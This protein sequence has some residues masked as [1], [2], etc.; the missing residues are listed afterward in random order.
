[1]QNIAKKL[2]IYGHEPEIPFHNKTADYD[3]WDTKEAIRVKTKNNA[4]K[5][6]FEFMKRNDAILVLN[7]E[8]NKLQNYVGENTLLELGFAHVL[9]KKLFLL[10]SIPELSYTSEIVSMKP[11]CLNG[12]IE[13]IKKH[14]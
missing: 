12:K 9:N 13:N 5:K 10:N 3:T 8:K 11:I 1:M 2:E 6:N 4:I 7:E 14:I